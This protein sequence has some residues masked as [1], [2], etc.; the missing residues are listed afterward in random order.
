MQDTFL[1]NAPFFIF[2]KLQTTNQ[3]KYMLK[4]RM[5][6][7]ISTEHFNS[8]YE[9]ELSITWIYLGFCTSCI[10]SWFKYEDMF[11]LC[12]ECI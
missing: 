6:F 5:H 7:L 4:R 3:I 11:R 8:Y 10:P 9:N 12:F 2:L 1:S